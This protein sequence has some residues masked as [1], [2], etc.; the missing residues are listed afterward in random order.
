MTN[1]GIIGNENLMI[2]TDG[3]DR[4]EKDSN[5]YIYIYKT[6][7]IQS[8]LSNLDYFLI[9]NVFNKEARK[10][11]HCQLKSYYFSCLPNI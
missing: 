4:I 6:K 8:V 7:K 10:I 5:I 1:C 2:E 11:I 9:Y 3:H